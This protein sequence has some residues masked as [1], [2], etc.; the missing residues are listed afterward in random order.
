MTNVDHETVEDLLRHATPRPTPPADAA[1][2]ARAAIR[3]EWRATVGR[4]QRR[5]KAVGYALAAT[6][7]V[8][9][10]AALDLLRTPAPAAVQVASI[11]KSVGPVYL[12]GEQAE[13]HETGGLAAIMSGQTVVTGAGAGLA[14]AWGDGGSLRLDEQTRVEFTDR[15]SIFLHEGRV[16][17]DSRDAALE[18]GAV[19]GDSPVFRLRT[20]LGQVQHVGTQYMVRIDRGELVV[21]VREGEVHIDGDYFDH[22]AVSGEQVTLSGSQRPG[23]LSIAA[24]GGDWEWIEETTPVVDVDGRNLYEFLAWVSRELGL[25]IR[26]L[27]DAESVAR[28][29]ILRGSI[30]SRP[31]DALRMRLASAA[32]AW[33]IEEGVIYVGSEP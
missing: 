24:A 3:N 15:E 31:A 6:A 13:L 27:S 5:R 18:S 30:D 1:A 4:R 10:F 33:R 19:D 17:F 22:N 25:Q 16:Y 8:G 7:I 32:L 11:D 20:E 9:T 23:V 26:Y 28:G 2:S 12:L 29:A 21:S 14:I